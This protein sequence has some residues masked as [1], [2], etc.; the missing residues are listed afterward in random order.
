MQYTGYDVVK[1]VVEKNQEKFGSG[2]IR[3]VHGDAVNVDLPKADLLICKEVL[4][5]LPNEEIHKF[6]KQLPKFAFCLITNGVDPET[7]SSSNPELV[8]GGYYYRPLDLTAPPFNVKGAKM[9][10]QVDGWAPR[11]LLLC[12]NLPM[13]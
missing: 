4:Q 6:L 3:F 8:M 12:Q 5:H 13:K 1:S 7:K 11:Q 10:I 2:S 9:L